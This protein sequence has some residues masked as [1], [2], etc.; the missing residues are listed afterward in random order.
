MVGDS[1]VPVLNPTKAFYDRISKAYDLIADANEHV[2][3]ERGIE[4]LAGRCRPP[5]R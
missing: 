2:A 1:D 4:L 5:R 3:R